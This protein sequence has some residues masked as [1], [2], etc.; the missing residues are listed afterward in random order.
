M[1]DAELNARLFRDGYVHLPFL[2]GEAVRELRELFARYHE[3]DTITGLYVASYRCGREV[4]EAVN[5]ASSR[6]FSEAIDRHFR[7]IR[8]LGG[9]FIAKAFDENNLLH[10]H[11]DWNIVDE[12]RYRSFTVWVPL[13]DVDDRNGAMY[14]LP[15]SHEWIRGYRHI[16]IPCV[17]G[18]VYG[19]A[20]KHCVPVYMKAGEALVFDH[21]LVHASMPNRTAEVRVAATH[22]IISGPGDMRIYLNNNGTVEEYACHPEYYLEPSAQ[23]G[24][25]PFPKLGDVD[26]KPVQ[27]DE[28]EFYRLAGMEMPVQPPPAK[29]ERGPK[30]WWAGIKKRFN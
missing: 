7:D 1:K 5:E 17:Y 26:F 6:I 29:P 10:P 9:T 25:H 3:R 12:C 16:T 23:T 2:D 14:V 13:Q 11:Q 28:R 27:V 19:L 15:G 8:P 21:A 22:S 30:N 18:K 4:M 24:P 20:W